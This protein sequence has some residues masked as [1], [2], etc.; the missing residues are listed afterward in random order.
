MSA[1]SFVDTNVLLYAYDRAA[2][3][4]QDIAKKVLQN[5]WW[6]RTGALSMQVLQEFYV[7]V[8]RKIASRCQRTKRVK[9]SRSTRSGA[10]K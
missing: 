6:Q 1:R 3:T 5:L 9:S 4:K 7:N 8:T 2:K 10:S